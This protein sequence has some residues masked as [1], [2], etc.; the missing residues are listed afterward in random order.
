MTKI[1]SAVL[2][3]LFMTALAISAAA[4]NVPDGKIVV[5]NTTA[6]PNGIF[7]LKQKYEQVDNQFK[8]RSQEL[9]G[10]A[11]Q[12][13]QIENEIKTKGNVLPPEKLRELQERYEGLKREGTRKQEDL[14]NDY[15]KAVEVAT[16]PV[17]DKLYQFINNYAAKNTISMVV[18][19]AGMAQSGGL[20]YWDP[21]ADV[22]EDFISEYNK[23][24]PVAGMTATP[25]GAKPA[26]G[27]PAKPAAKPTG[28]GKPN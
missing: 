17:R 22:T 20:A 9:E 10:I 16:K 24:N 2:A 3:A 18:N 4:Q 11:Q 8:P 27:A 23:A 14:K 13:Q 6:F 15:E 7:E 25:P 12:M 1:K 28:N 26:P 5:L 21:K 19:L